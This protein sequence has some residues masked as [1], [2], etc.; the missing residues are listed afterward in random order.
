MH[1]WEGTGSIFARGSCRLYYT[2][3]MGESLF[4]LLVVLR[5]LPRVAHHR[6]TSASATAA[7]WKAFGFFAIGDN[8]RKGGQQGVQ[9]AQG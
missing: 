9:K 8:R 6:G 1:I 4:S 3:S 2:S 5:Q 7:E